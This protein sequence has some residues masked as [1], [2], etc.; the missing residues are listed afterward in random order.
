MRS[1]DEKDLKAKHFAVGKDE[2]LPIGYASASLIED[3]RADNVHAGRAPR[4]GAS[5]DLDR[6]TNVD[7]RPY[8]KGCKKG[9]VRLGGWGA[10]SKEHAPANLLGVTSDIGQ[11]RISANVTKVEHADLAYSA[12]RPGLPTQRRQNLALRLDQ[13]RACL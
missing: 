3:G 6:R 2:V 10:A 11:G 9:L 5:T 8:T 12:C 7:H 1:S 4:W 13:S